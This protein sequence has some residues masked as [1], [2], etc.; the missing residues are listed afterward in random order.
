MN[1]PLTIQLYVFKEFLKRFIPALVVLF[2]IF[3]LQTFWVYFDELAG[4]GLS[5]WVIFKFFYYFS[6]NIL[7]YSLPL[8]ILLAGIMT[9]GSLGEKYELA[10]I[11]SSGV[12]V[13]KSMQI[14]LIFNF[15][16]GIFI[17]IFVNTIQPAGN[18][19]F[20]NLRVA[21]ARKMPAAV[22]RQGV[23]SEIGDF[24]IKVN[25]KYGKNDHKL[26]DIIIHQEIN[27][28]PDKVI[29][30][31][32]GAFFSDPSGN[33]L[34]LKL[35]DG[36][37]FEDLTR[38]QKKSTDRQKLPALYSKF[39]EYH[40]N[41]DLS[42]MN[43]LKEKD[44][45]MKLYHMLDMK[46]LTYYIDS[47]TTALYEFKEKSYKELFR[48]HY[49]YVPYEKVLPWEKLLSKLNL[50][51]SDW[52]SIY[53]RVEMKIQA[54]PGFVKRKAVQIREKQ[55]FLNKYKYTWHEKAAMP[56][57]IFLLFLVGI[58][59]GAMIRKGGFG[60][61]F[62]L[63]IIIYAA[64]Y[65]LNMLGASMAEEGI[66]P[67]GLGAWLPVIVLLPLV[68]YMIY[69]VQFA[70]ESKT[71]AMIKKGY[72]KISSKFKSKEVQTDAIFVPV[73]KLNSQGID[74]VM[75]TYEL[76]KGFLLYRK[77]EM[78]FKTFFDFLY[79]TLQN[80]GVSY[81][82]GY[83]KPSDWFSKKHNILGEVLMIR[84]DR[85]G[86]HFIATNLDV[87]YVYDS[88]NDQFKIV[89]NSKEKFINYK[90]FK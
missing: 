36:E 49:E 34:T 46:G 57:Y 26:E 14:L 67:P 7:L 71:L 43:S 17:F 75:N 33:I 38:Q 3:I 42:K 21:I 62:V 86:N 66:I 28:L 24:S 53:S 68:T 22:I 37:Y 44:T 70:A 41:I 54:N 83:W 87:I 50:S 9:Y 39:R 48:R 6:P 76:K 19:K 60:L 81:I 12:S 23:F 27:A 82:L 20:T 69:A 78:N 16:L 47:L 40:I 1:R 5:L 10:A 56:F 52:E 35:Y 72:E 74:K 30:A 18:Q 51:P 59:L 29:I 11:K 2:F 55:K 15:V 89:K 8:A 79:K 63:G 4:K 31:K 13:F 85:N 84:I 73:E 25:R 80:T 90:E 88:D 32:K 58:P 61:P 64:F 77:H 65:M 45:K